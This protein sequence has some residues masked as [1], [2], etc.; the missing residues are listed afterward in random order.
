MLT[1]DQN[2]GLKVSHSSASIKMSKV[3]ILLIEDQDEARVMIRQML[4]EIG[5]TQIF[6]AVSG[7]EGMGFLDMADDMVDVV[8]CD[9]N[10]PSMSGLELLQ[11]LRSVQN[12]LPF[13]MITGRGDR[14]SVFEAKGAGVDGY[15]LK[16][17]SMRQL[18][19]KLRIICA[20]HELGL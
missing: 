8:L 13:M 1:I 18:E 3:K 9:W 10:M 20:R 14:A 16:P 5:V 6:E 4:L 12:G 11:Q 19:A 17:F 15:I 2:D 7:R